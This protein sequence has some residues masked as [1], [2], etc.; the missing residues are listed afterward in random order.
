[1]GIKL[2]ILVLKYGRP[3]QKESCMLT[4]M[5]TNI[6]ILVHLKFGSFLF[7]QIWKYCSKVKGI[8][9]LN[10][11]FEANFAF[12]AKKISSYPS[13]SAYLNQLSFVKQ[14]DL[15]L[16]N[17][18][19]FELDNLR[20]KELLESYQKHRKDQFEMSVYHYAMLVNLE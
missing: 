13:L 11:Y 12:N 7:K 20:I 5:T 17:R 2:F 18:S 15:L 1:M 3:D 19:V 10:Q 16:S 8:F 9:V 6:G 14:G 4:L